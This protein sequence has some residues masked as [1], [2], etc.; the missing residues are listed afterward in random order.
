MR[1]AL[2]PSLYAPYVGG[3]EVLTASLAAH[4]VGRGHEVEVWTGRSRD[5][6]LQEDEV[7]DGIRVRRFVF[8]MPRYEPRLSPT[9]QPLE[10]RRS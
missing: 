4:L 8:A 5:D 1:I 7:I 2:I 6:E 3:V 10:S 9:S